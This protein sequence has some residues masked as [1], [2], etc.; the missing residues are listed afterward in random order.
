MDIVDDIKR[1]GGLAPTHALLAQG[2]SGKAIARSIH[3]GRILRVRQGWYALPDAP[4]EWI[5]ACRV[6]GRL[7]CISG[8]RA[9]A[10]WTSNRSGLHVAVPPNAARLRSSSDSRRPLDRADGVTV[11]WAT[12]SGGHPFLVPPLECLAHLTECQPADFVVAAADSAIRFGL[13]DAAAWRSVVR[14][15]PA[16]LRSTLADVDAESEAITESLAR[17]RLRAH[18][19][20]VRTQV[21]VA[22][23]IRVDLVVGRRLVVEL[24]GSY[25]AM[26][27]Q[28]E[29]D[30][31]RD[32]TLTTL[33]FRVV[34]FSYRQVMGSWDR[35][36]ASILAAL[37]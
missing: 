19:L 5:A 17:V 12:T 1:R 24:D 29:S 9:H 22:R 4:T 35:V 16:R 8:A 28:F 23:G 15:L 37:D 10:L 26:P 32:A 6:G 14:D 21:R 20:T 31:N 27:D 36:L 7:T 3:R 11:H 18:G 30:R 2:W 33:G 34:R 25:R 13:V